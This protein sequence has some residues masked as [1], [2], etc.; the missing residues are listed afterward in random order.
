MFW[1]IIH[2]NIGRKPE[3]PNAKPVTQ[4]VGEGTP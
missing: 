3:N 2:G 4:D 1:D